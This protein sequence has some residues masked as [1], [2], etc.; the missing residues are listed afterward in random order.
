[1]SR[2]PAGREKQI[3]HCPSCGSSRIHTI[4]TDYHTRVRG[5]EVVVPN[6]E[7]DE[8]L[9]CGEVLFGP[10]AMRQLEHYRKIVPIPK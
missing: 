7:R 5:E 3:R 4:R 6:L 9:D 8:C 1:M 10:A 2:K